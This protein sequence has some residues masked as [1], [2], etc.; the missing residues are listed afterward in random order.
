VTVLFRTPYVLIL[1]TVHIMYGKYAVCVF[2]ARY[3][4]VVVIC[5]NPTRKY[6]YLTVTS[7]SK[8]INVGYVLWF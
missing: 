8:L 4:H 1:T 6:A 7:T 2:Y 5:T 3:L